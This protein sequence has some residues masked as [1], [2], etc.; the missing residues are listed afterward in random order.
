MFAAIAAAAA[1]V[2]P[3]SVLNFLAHSTDLTEGSSLS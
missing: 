3:K 2:R 1:F